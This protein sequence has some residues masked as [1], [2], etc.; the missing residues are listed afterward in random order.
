MGSRAN[1]RHNDH[2]LQNVS[3]ATLEERHKIYH[4]V[5]NMTSYIHL[6]RVSTARSR[7]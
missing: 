6:D 4:A 2:A 7:W 1:F 3:D 5:L